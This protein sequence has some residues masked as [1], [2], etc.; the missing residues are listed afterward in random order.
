MA[1]KAQNSYHLAFTENICY[2]QFRMASEF[3]ALAWP[4]W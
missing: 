1:H 2:S 3:W 4:G